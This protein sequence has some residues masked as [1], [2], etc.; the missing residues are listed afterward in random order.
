[1]ST[2]RDQVVE[3]IPEIIDSSALAKYVARETDWTK[4]EA[5]VA[6]ADSLELAL[7]ETANA[8]WKKI[9]KKEM[10]L[11]TAKAIIMNLSGNIWFLD[12]RDY[13]DRALEIAAKYD[14]S[15]YDALF[16]ACAQKENSSLVSCDKRQMEI[17]Q[18]LGIKTIAV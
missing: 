11:E 1:M 10:N 12:Q 8:L 4:V 14:I 17:A 5:Y 9:R 18:E 6:S 13:L 2:K 3:Q 16:L 7:K 15:V